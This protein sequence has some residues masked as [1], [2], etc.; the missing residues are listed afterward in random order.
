M[1]EPFCSQLETESLGGNRVLRRLE[2]NEAV[3]TTDAKASTV[4]SLENSPNQ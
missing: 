2:D 1:V 4:K 3:R